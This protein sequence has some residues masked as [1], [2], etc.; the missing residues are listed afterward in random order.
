MKYTTLGRSGAVVSTCSLGTMTFGAETPA[1]VAHQ[2]LDTYFE[3][4]GTFVETADVYSGGEAERIIGDWLAKRSPAVRDN[5]FLAGKGRFPVGVE[6]RD[7]GLSR[8]HLSRALD[9]SLR[10]LGCEHIDLYQLHAWDPLTPLEESLGFLEDAVRSGKISYGGLSNFTGWQIA[11]AAAH[12]R[13]RFPLISMQPQYSLLVREVEWEIVPACLATGLGVLPWS[14]LGGGWLTGKYRRDERPSGATR[15]GEDPNRGVE[16]YDLRSTQ[17][18]TWRTL[19]AVAAVANARGATMSQVSLAWLGAQPGVTSIV[20]GA[21]TVEQLEDNLGAAG[22]E[23]SED[24]LAILSEASNPGAAQ[25]P[26]G[27]AGLEQRSRSLD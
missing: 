6:P 4:G 18:R 2:Q 7:A 13:G 10:R 20:L 3:A 26:Y 22:L 5:A 27:P 11:L 25:Y 24:E 9:A 19:D 12:A 14:P 15:L 16:A 1:E 17:E 8:R 21:R 23:L